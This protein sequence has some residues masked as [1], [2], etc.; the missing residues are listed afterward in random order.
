MWPF[1]KLCGRFDFLPQLVAICCHW[2]TKHSLLMLLSYLL[3]KASASQSQR[4]TSALQKS[5]TLFANLYGACVT[6]YMHSWCSLPL[7]WGGQT[8]DTHWIRITLHYVNTMSSK[9]PW[10][11]SKW[12]HS[13]IKLLIKQNHLQIK[14]CC[15]GK[16]SIPPKQI[17]L[18]ACHYPPV[19]LEIPVLVHT[20]LYLYFLEPHNLAFET[21]S[22]LHKLI[23]L[24]DNFYGFE[25][26]DGHHFLSLTSLEIESSHNLC[27]KHKRNERTSPELWTTSCPCTLTEYDS[28]ANHIAAF[29]SEHY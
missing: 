25:L 13:S 3:P 16:I 4:Q 22:C 21:Y 24:L 19:P 10:S 11:D 7:L 6:A 2:A 17:R 8:L 1:A 14:L 20:F 23:N 12:S 26:H 9:F 28:S 29:A 5:Y 27:P 18:M 15:S